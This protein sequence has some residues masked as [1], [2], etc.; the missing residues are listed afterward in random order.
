MVGYRHSRLSD[1]LYTFA[2]YAICIIVLIVIM[3]PLYF[4]IIAS[5]STPAYVTL[6]KVWLVPKGITHLGYREIFRDQRIW[7]GY[8][9]TILYSVTGTILTLAVVLPAAYA[10]SRKKLMIRNPLMIFFVI[11]MF[12][13][14][15]MIPT[16]LV[17]L[18]LGLVD[19][20]WALLLPVA[21]N[22]FYMIIARTFFASTIPLELYDT[23]EIDGCSQFQ[24]FIKIV[25]PLSNAII[26][27]IGLYS[28]VGHW[29]SYFP[30]LMYIRRS[31]LK[32]LQIILR[33]ILIR[34]QMSD[35]LSATY[36]SIDE[37]LQ[38]IADTIKYGVIIVSTLPI[39]AF[40]PFL[41]KYFAKG[42]MI[43]A[44]KG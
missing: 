3:Y 37:E 42:V 18:R 6:G 12:F 40:Y 38:Q 36:S 8:R 27:V 5:I 44:L 35:R 25:L 7:I 13:N 34:N 16:Y 15:G 30:A 20:I 19:K 17:V 41:Q 22:A 1:R 28:L 39:M 9:N 11:T 29:N 26:A 33:D 32:P 31:S 43:G 2:L 23:A 21:F 4:V 14:G 10:M 24:V